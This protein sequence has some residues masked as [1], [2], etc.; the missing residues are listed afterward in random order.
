MR[1]RKP[2]RRTAAPLRFEDLEMEGWWT[3]ETA[4]FQTF[5]LR[6]LASLPG[7]DRAEDMGFEPFGNFLGWKEAEMVTEMLD[8]IQYADDVD[9]LISDIVG[10]EEDD[11]Y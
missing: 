1:N 4:E 5:V 11:E 6:L 8:K 9:Q 2:I 10:D 3:S 7:G